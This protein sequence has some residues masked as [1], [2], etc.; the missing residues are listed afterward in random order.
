M[1]DLEIKMDKQNEELR[2]QW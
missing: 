2:N 1:Q